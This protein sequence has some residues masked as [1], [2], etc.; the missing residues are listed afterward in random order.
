MPVI[1]SDSGDNPTAGGVGDTPSMLKEFIALGVGDAVMQGPH[2]AA[3]VEACIAAGVGAEVELELG[4]KLDYRNAK[5]LT[6]KA[7]VHAINAN[8]K[9]EYDVDANAGTGNPPR[10]RKRIM[11]RAA[12]L[13]VLPGRDGASCGEQ[14]VLLVTL[15]AERKPFHWERDFQILGLEPS[16]HG[17]LVVKIG[18]LVPDLERLACVNL[19]ALSPG[20]VFADVKNIKYENVKRP[21]YPQD[22]IE[23]WSARV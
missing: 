5:P 10:I 18:Y 8:P 17:I 1:I 19:M 4:G 11:P 12:V 21:I 6:V 7:V 23:G 13:K 2:D 22:E 15:T 3:A 20:S 14:G 16:K 9:L